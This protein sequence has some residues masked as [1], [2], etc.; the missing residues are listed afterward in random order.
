MAAPAAEVVVRGDEKLRQLRVSDLVL[1]I[2]NFQLS[3]LLP[4]ESDTLFYFYI[5]KYFQFSIFN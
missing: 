4:K 5:I 1:L 3:T 2:F